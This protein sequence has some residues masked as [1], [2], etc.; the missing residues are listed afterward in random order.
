[1]RDRAAVERQGVVRLHSRRGTQFAGTFTGPGPFFN[2][3]K[4]A[5][6]L[7]YFERKC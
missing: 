7:I 4:V 3:L 6:K 2:L 1:M 5:V